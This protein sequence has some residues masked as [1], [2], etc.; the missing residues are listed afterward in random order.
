[1]RAKIAES[2]SFVLSHRLS[3]AISDSPEIVP[4][5]VGSVQ[6]RG[7]TRMSPSHVSVSSFA[8]SALFTVN[9]HEIG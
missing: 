3:K 5:R 8:L 1:M 2:L 6:V 7:E 4:N 9:R